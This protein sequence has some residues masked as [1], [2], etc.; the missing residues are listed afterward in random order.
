VNNP[1]DGSVRRRRSAR[2]TLIEH[3][4]VKGSVWADAAHARN[5]LDCGKGRAKCDADVLTG[6]LSTSATLIANISPRTESLLRW[7]PRA[8]RFTNNPGANRFLHYEYRPP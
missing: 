8:E 7:D 3:K 5:F 4:T 6:H 1:V 2:K